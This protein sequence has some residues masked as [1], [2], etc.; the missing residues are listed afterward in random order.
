MRAAA[1]IMNDDLESAEAGLADGASS[2]H[3]VCRL[4]YVMPGLEA[5][6]RRR[7]E[8]TLMTI[9]WG[10]IDG[11]GNDCLLEGYARIRAGNN[12]RR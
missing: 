11:Q 6:C 9:S 1:H 12:A 10:A 8:C 2:F 3:K 5:D 4:C 7:K